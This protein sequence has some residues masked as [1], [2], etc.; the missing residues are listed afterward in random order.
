MGTNVITA[1]SEPL[2]VVALKHKKGETVKSHLHIGRRRQIY[3]TQT[4]FIVK[5]GRIKIDLYNNAKK[6]V[7]SL[8]LGVGSLFIS[9]AGGHAVTYLAD[10]EIIEIKNG[11]FI[12]DEVKI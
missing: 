11:P 9:L 1:D 12:K 5:R 8:T 7:Q 3:S 6:Y 10:T 4:C 2:Q